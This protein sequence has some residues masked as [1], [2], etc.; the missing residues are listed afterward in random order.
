[1]PLSS[2]LLHFGLKNPSRSG[3]VRSDLDLAKH[4]Q[5]KPA[6]PCL[7][8]EMSASD[9]AAMSVQKVESLELAEGR[10]MLNLGC[11]RQFH[12]AWVN[13]DLVPINQSVCKVDISRGLPFSDNRFD[14]IY[15]SHLLEHLDHNQGQMLIGECF[16]ALKPGGILR[17]VVPDLEQI[18]RL[19]LDFHQQAVAGNK[20]AAANYR[21][22]KL[23]LFDQ[24]VR[25][26]SGGSMGRYIS[27]PTSPN[28]NFVR[29]RLGDEIQNCLADKASDF[30]AAPTDKT[31][32]GSST[33]IQPTYA[34]EGS[35]WY[36]LRL[37]LAMWLVRRLLGRSARQALQEGLFRAKGEI[38]RWMYD[39]FSLT[40][41]CQQFG[42]ENLR[43]CSAWESQIENFVEFQLD[44]ERDRVRKP[45]SIFF[46][47]RKPVSDYRF[48]S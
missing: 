26:Q 22:M 36:R 29:Q 6:P 28:Q 41:L 25:R 27:D 47:C 23:E 38:H 18:A 8:D 12:P 7:L 37:R 24:M 39:Q 42:F 15:H 31:G 9:S 34:S 19:Y 48:L 20:V 1:M 14:A 11:G 33:P 3:R 40:E 32:L 46:E 2:H 45:D 10:Q 13:V 35:M 43:V 5:P 4:N 30:G 21:W 16:R 17:I 44:T